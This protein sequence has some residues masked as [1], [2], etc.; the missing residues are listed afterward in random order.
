MIELRPHNKEAVDKIKEKL[1]NGNKK[2]IYVA[3]T[4]CGKSYVFMG[5]TEALQDMYPEFRMPYRPKVLYILPK[6]VIK[7]NLS[8]YEDFSK[9]TCTVDFKTYNYFTS[10]KRG[11][12][13][14]RDYDLIV[15]DECH[16]LGADL[17]GKNI[18]KAMNASNALFLGL[19]ATP[20]RDID[21]TN[22]SMYFDTRVDG[23]SV[24]DAIREGLMPP[25][26]YQLCVPEKDVKQL[27]REYDYKVRAVV[28]YMDSAEAVYEIVSSSN[29]NKWICFFPDSKTIH[30]SMPVIKEIFAGYKILI[31]LSSLKNLDEVIKEV[32]ENEKVVILSV[33]IMLE[34][35]HLDGISGI[36]IFR[37]VSS[38]ICFQQMI[39]RTSK[40]GNKV[41]PVIIDTSQTAQKILAK[42]IRENT[43]GK[44]EYNKVHPGESN[45]D[46]LAVG[47][48]GVINYNLNQVLRLLDKSFA[49][50]QEIKELSQKTFTE[51]EKFGGK[52]HKSYQELE[53]SGLD[54]K[55]FKACA[56]LYGLEAEIAYNS[57]YKES[58]A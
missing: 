35:C 22:V 1:E 53:N 57:Y 23:L 46:I 31:L 56:K 9:L 47:I 27:E 33:N 10:M 8:G 42:L 43:E 30:N 48:G 49:R 39:G 44:A 55:K 50:E 51:Y 18:V 52:E 5:L 21:K 24:W 14:F 15:I 2:V 37:N 7:N 29:R 34:G 17:Y 40:I 45:K 54:F 26:I 32:K 19:T 3:G 58:F 12:E 6:H 4:G 38:T 41:S 36:V 28:D 16:H 11:Y 13:L 25:F 20:Y